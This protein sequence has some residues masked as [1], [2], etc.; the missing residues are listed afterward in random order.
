MFFKER[1][2]AFYLFAIN[3]EEEIRKIRLVNKN[4]NVKDIGN[5]NSEEDSSPSNSIENFYKIDLE[6]TIGIADVHINNPDDSTFLKTK[7]QL[8][9]YV[10]LIMHPG[11]VPP[12]KEERCM[13]IAHD[14]RLNSGCLSRQVGAVITD[15]EYNIISTG[16]NSVPDKQ[17][18][19]I[20][21]SLFSIIRED[22]KDK[23]GMSTFEL[24]DEK[25]K[26][27][28]KNSTKEI[29]FTPLK[30]RHCAYCFKDA[31]NAYKDKS[32][33]V[34]T[35]AIHAEEMAFLQAAKVGSP[36]IKGGF[37]FATASPC[38]LC[39][40]KA[41]HTGITKIYYIDQY[42]GIS[43]KHILSCGEEKYQ[44]EMIHYRG[45][46]GKAYS[47]LYTQIIPYKDEIYMLLGLHFK[48]SDN[49]KQ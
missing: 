34:Y 4:L 48:R 23:I 26:T 15:S 40:K 21:R 37:L 42:P 35:R 14:A 20:L 27:Y 11:L 28:L 46:V 17:V 19:C 29:D 24:T 2:S 45:A 30:G 33:Q 39:S 31:Y 12:T 16:W 32:N 5:L 3:T 38:E 47:Q 41:Y 43:Y 8:I 9:R 13:Q 1:Y 22:S 36:S 10:S 49:D 6:R 25:Y 7:K 44:P 18:P